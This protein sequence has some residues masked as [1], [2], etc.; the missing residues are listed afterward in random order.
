MEIK[1]LIQ[2]SNNPI[3]TSTLSSRVRKL[4]PLSTD[5]VVALEMSYNRGRPFPVVLR[6]LL[7]IAGQNCYVLDYGP[8]DSQDDLQ[9]WVRESLLADNDRQI[10]GPFFAIDIY[11]GDKFLFVYLDGG[12]DDPDVYEA[13]PYDE[14]EAT[15]INYV[16]STLSNLIN[17][18]LVKVLNGYSPF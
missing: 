18:R 7:Y 15:W 11:G 4:E 5:Q 16:N 6:E 3:V 9:E 8:T 2:L 14:P 17:H 13:T 1:Y 10:S 12:K